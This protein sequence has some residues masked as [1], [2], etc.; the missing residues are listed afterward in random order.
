MNVGQGDRSATAILAER[1]VLDRRLPHGLRAAAQR[2][3]AIG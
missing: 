3:P 2:D 1:S